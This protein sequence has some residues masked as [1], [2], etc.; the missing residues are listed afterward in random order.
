MRLSPLAVIASPDAAGGTTSLARAA[1]PEP[2]VSLRGVG[3]VFKARRRNLPSV[4]ALSPLDAEIGRGE[5][6]TIVGPSGCG[7]S[8]LLSLIAGLEAPSSGAIAIAGS[9]VTG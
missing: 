3:K 1:A 4:E 6:L 9:P 7:K 8:T 5:F 2:L